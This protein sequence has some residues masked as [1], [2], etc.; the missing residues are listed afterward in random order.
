ML[1]EKEALDALL[2]VQG[3]L[4]Q[5]G[6][7]RHAETLIAIATRPLLARGLACRM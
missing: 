4:A 6:Y 3:S 7:V 1:C 5:P 2:H